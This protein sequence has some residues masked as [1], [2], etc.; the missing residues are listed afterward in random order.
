MALA[1][2]AGS[3]VRRSRLFVAGDKKLL[4]VWEKDGDTSLWQ[5]LEGEP[6]ARVNRRAQISCWSRPAA[7]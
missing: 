5:D 6:A 4:S 7:M 1:N 2:G 3:M